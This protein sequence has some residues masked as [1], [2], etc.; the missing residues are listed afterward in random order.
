MSNLKNKKMDKEKIAEKVFD[1]FTDDFQIN[2]ETILHSYYKGDD[3]DQIVELVLNK[4]GKLYGSRPH[5]T[6]EL[7]VSN[8]YNSDFSWILY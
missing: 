8:D 7:I 3:K 1:Q 4:V 2:I 6:I 5:K